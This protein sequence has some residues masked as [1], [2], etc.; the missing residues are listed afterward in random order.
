M[1]LLRLVKKFNI[2]NKFD[3]KIID[4]TYSIVL[5]VLKILNNFDTINLPKISK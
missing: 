4:K 2:K 5:S 1:N 3:K